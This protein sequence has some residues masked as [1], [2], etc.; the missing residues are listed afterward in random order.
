M[1]KILYLLPFITSSILYGFVGVI[2]RFTLINPLVVL[3][4]VI[5]WLSGFLMCKDKWWGGFLGLLIGIL[6]IWMGNGDFKY[7]IK[8]IIFGIVFCI[9]Y[10]ICMIISYNK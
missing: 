4:L 8:E 1:T 6:L 3:C 5:L 2:S 7:A 9:Y 10:I